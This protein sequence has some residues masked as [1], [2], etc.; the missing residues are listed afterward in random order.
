MDNEYWWGSFTPELA[1]EGWVDNGED[2]PYKKLGD[3][4]RWMQIRFY[5]DG[6]IYSYCKCCGFIHDCSKQIKDMPWRGEY[7]PVNEYKYCPECG[8]NMH[9]RKRY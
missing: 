8:K 7:D 1:K 6:A 9:I 5:H 2:P 4:G 3:N